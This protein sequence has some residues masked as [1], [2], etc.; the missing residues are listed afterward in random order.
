MFLGNGRVHLLQ[1]I[2]ESGSIT[3]ASKS[4]HMSYKKAW[5]QIDHMNEV[6]DKPLVQ[7]SSGGKGGGGALLTTEGENVVIEFNRLTSK[8]VQIINKEKVAFD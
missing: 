7:T 5:E 8:L 2:K 3:A 4:M 1:A 6:S